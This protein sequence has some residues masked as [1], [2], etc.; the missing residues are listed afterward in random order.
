MTTQPN[1]SVIPNSTALELCNLSSKPLV[2]VLCSNHNYGR[3]LDDAIQ[4]VLSQTYDSFELIICD[5]GSSD[6]SEEIYQKYA[7]A[8][9]K[10]IRQ[11]NRGQGNA[12]TQ[13][14]NVSNGE[15]ICFLDADDVFLP[16]KIELAVNEFQAN[17]QAGL[18]I[19][20][21]QPITKDGKTL[22]RPVPK[23]LNTGWLATKS[24]QNGGMVPYPPTSGISIRRE[25]GQDIFPIPDK[26]NRAADVFIIGMTGFITEIVAIP[27]SLTYWRWHGGNI[28]GGQAHTSESVLD[29]IRINRSL[30]HE[31]QEMLKNRFPP[32]I[33][34]RL[35]L[36]DREQYL[37]TMLWQHILA[38]NSTDRID[39]LHL[40]TIMGK[41]PK[42]LKNQVRRFLVHLPAPISSFVVRNFL[43]KKYYL[44]YSVPQIIKVDH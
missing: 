2:S 35:R 17:P 24:L 44:D 1:K 40:R 37:Y 12:L 39:K 15:I 22:G 41:L 32:E 28:S 25:C 7:H 34:N 27:K 29:L 19:H 8:N 30:F 26:F 16:N 6:N 42:T 3:F 23:I 14:F 11:E 13:A 5:D 31:Q 10:V 4:S 21:V 18:C 36:E 38:S 33:S 43:N 9:V 20:F